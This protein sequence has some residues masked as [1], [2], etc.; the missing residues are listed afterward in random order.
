MEGGRVGY[1]VAEDAGVCAAVVEA[2]DGAEAFLAGG[3]PYLQTD[4]GVGVCVYYPLRH[5]RCPDGGGCFGWVEGAFAVP[6]YEG[7]FAY[8]L[9]AEDD[10][11]GF[12]GG[13]HFLV[14]VSPRVFFG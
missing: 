3:V 7:G 4:E 14:T 10:D 6:G 11:F 12:E 1:R 2:G 9:G 13:R 8:T 5:E